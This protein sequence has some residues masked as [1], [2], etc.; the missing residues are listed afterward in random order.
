MKNE[1][2]ELVKVLRDGREARE[3]MPRWLA[4]MTLAAIPF[5]EAN[6][7]KAKIEKY[8]PR[9]DPRSPYKPAKAN[10]KAAL[11]MGEFAFAH[12]LPHATV[13]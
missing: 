8:A 6:V 9:T 1:E 2:V 4:E 7:A 13:A 10:L 3:R 12:S 5:S 11:Y